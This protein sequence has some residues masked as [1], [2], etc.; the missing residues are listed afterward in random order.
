LSAAR[1]KASLVEELPTSNVV[2]ENNVCCVNVEADLSQQSRIIELVNEK[3]SNVEDINEV[4]VDVC[5]PD[6]K[7]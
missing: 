3:A 2:C 7:P 4:K 6:F 5:P 1:I